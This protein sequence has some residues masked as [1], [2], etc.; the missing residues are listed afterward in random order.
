MIDQRT[1]GVWWTPSSGYLW[2][3]AGQDWYLR[4]APSPAPSTEY[5]L[6]KKPGLFQSLGRLTMK[7]KQA[8]VRQAIL[9]FANQH[10]QLHEPEKLDPMMWLRERQKKGS[11]VRESFTTWRVAIGLLR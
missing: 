1:F 8:N 9:E 4:A 11:N 6:M 3:R 7:G 10:G 2:E 5:E